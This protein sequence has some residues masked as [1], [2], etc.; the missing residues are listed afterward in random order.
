MAKFVYDG[1]DFPSVKAEAP[2]TRYLKIIMSP[3]VTGYERATILFSHI[4]PGSSTGV[5]THPV[6]EIRKAKEIRKLN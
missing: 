3:E 6:D 5:H 2:N 1:W 4:P